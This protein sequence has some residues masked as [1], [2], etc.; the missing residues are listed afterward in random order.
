VSEWVKGGV[1]MEWDWGNMVLAM[2]ALVGLLAGVIQFYTLAQSEQTV[3]DV[4]TGT[5]H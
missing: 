5:S 2:S 3:P 4:P 1:T